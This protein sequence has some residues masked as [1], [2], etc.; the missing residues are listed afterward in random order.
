MYAGILSCYAQGFGLIAAAAQENGWKIHFAEVARI[1]EGGC[2]IRA[3]LLNFL[4]K[5]F[6]KSKGKKVRGMQTVR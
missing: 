5:A 2:I 3:K 4:H 1:W 6:Q